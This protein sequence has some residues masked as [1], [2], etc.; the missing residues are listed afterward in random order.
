MNAEKFKGLIAEVTG[1]LAGKA[2]D[3]RL[4]AELNEH[5]PPDG[6]TFSKIEAACRA[7]V[8]DGWLC[9]RE[10]GGIRFGRPIQPGSATA[11]FSVDVVRYADL[12]GPHHRHPN[13]EIDMI[14]PVT[15]AAKF[16]G[17]GR[18]W[19]VYGPDTAHRPTV[20]GGEAMILYLLPGGAIEF[21]KKGD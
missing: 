18:G 14:M 2:L 19:L 20:S 11:G 16:D 8:E 17:R 1:T 10:R 13:G 3:A 5:F 21:T 4:E 15:P 12:A 6:T 7:G 9:E